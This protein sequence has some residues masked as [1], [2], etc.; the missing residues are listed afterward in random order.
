M[1]IHVALHH[2]TNYRYDRLV[3]LGPQIVRL[4]PAPHCRTRILSYS[5][6]IAPDKHFINWQQD[7]QSNYLARL[8]FPEQTREFNVEVDLVAEMSVLNPFDFF[9]EPDAEKFP[10]HYDPTLDH[11]LEPFQLKCPLTPKFQAYLATVSREALGENVTFLNRRR[12]PVPHSEVG[13]DVHAH[14]HMPEVGQLH[15]DP[16]KDTRPRT[17]DFLVAFNQRLWKDIKYLIRLEPGVQKPEETLTTLSGSCRDSAWLLVQLFRH[18]GLA[19]RFVSGYLIQLKP[20]VKSLDGPSGAEQDGVDECECE[21]K[22]DMKVTRIHESPRVTKPY[23]EEQWKEI[24]RLGHT[25]DAA[26]KK[27]DVRLTM[28]GEPTFVSIDDMDGAEWNISALGPTKRPLADELIRRLQRRFAPGALLHYGQ[29]KAY[30]GESLPRWAFAC[31]W[32][33]DGKP[34]WENPALIADEKS[35]YGHTIDHSARFMAALADRIQADPQWIMPGYEDPFYH[36]WKERRLPAN[37]DPHKANLKDEEERA[38]LAK[39]LERGLDRVVGHVLPVQ[40]AWRNCFPIWASGPWFL[41]A[42]KLYLFPGDSPMGFRLPLDSLPWVSQSDYP[43]LNELDPTVARPP[44]PDRA[45]FRQRYLQVNTPARTKAAA[46]R[47]REQTEEAARKAELLDDPTK[48][49]GRGESAA[50][51]IRTAL[52]VEPRGGRLHVFMPPVATLEDYLELVA[53]IE[54]TAAQL[55][56]PVTIEGYTPPS[57]PRLNVLKVT[58][59]PG[60]IEVNMHPTSTWDEMVK[61]TTTLYEEARQTRLGTEKFMLDG[62][63]TG[64]GGGNH[65]VIG[66]AT[67]TDSP[68]LRRPDLLKSLIAYWQN[69][70]SLSFLFSSLSIGPTSQSP[71]IDEAR[72]D[73]L[74]ELEVAFKQIKNFEPVPAWQT[75][76][77]FRNLL[78]DATGNTHRAEFCIDKLYSPDSSSGRLGLLEMR[79]F[80]MPPHAEMSLAQQLLLRTLVAKFWQQPYDAKLVRWGTQIHDRWMLPHFVWSDLQDVVSDLK[81]AGYAMKSEWFAPHFEFRFPQFGDMQVRNTALELRQALEPWHVLGEEP[82]GGGTVRYVDSSLERVQVKARGLTDSRHIITCNGHAIPLHPTGTHGEYIAGVRYRAWQPASCLQPT[83]GVHAPITFDVVDSWNG[84]SIG[85]CT[86][87]VAHPG[88]RNYTSFPVNAYEAESRRLARFFRLGHTPGPV[89]VKRAEI[90]PEMPFTLDLRNV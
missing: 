1:S 13:E 62:R 83:I 86:Y 85:G 63:H 14:G 44:L 3:T 20:D 68:L 48:Q 80:E 23:T 58:P 9:L 70:P 75:D 35:Q 71:R 28:G 25:V 34:I 88:G 87:H 30:P 81:D 47:R 37:V 12:A 69:H 2:R 72:N 21:F 27:H 73:S 42:E 45:E 56:T 10:F 89:K 60:V 52:C 64:T 41:R 11:E 46:L 65:I 40:R 7:P 90:N 49:P 77:L 57:D 33:R 50:W 24:E 53:A 19:A 61:Q 66:G 59:D 6:R 78:I 51:I 29:G 31:Y 16:D 84:K 82:G 74:Y 55:K 79:A 15:P 43:Y 8:V 26:L 39:V 5:L 54:D 18:C 17:I 22:V 36:L 32:R 76:R 38:R 67:P 4:R